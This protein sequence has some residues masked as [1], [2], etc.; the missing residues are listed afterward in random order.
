MF[1]QHIIFPMIYFL[2]KWKKVDGK[3]VVLADAHHDSCPP[4]ML[5]IRDKLIEENYK[6]REY[7]VDISKLSSL[8]GLISLAGFMRI[9]PSCGTVIICDNFLPVASCRKKKETKVIQLWHGCGAF[10]KFGYDATYDI[11]KGYKGNVYRNYDLVTVSGK[12][13]IPHF[14][15]AMNAYGKVLDTGVCHTDRLFDDKYIIGCK[16]RFAKYYPKAKGKKVLLWAPTFRGNAGMANL[17]GKA[18]IDKLGESDKLSD[19]YII[20]SIHPHLL[21]K[22]DSEAMNTDELMVC[23]DVL[24][25]DYS[26]VF[27][28]ALLLGIPVIFFA[29]DYDKYSMDRGFYL[30]YNSL[31]GYVVTSF[32]ELEKAVIKTISGEDEYKEIRDKFIGDYMLGCDGNATERV[33]SIISRRM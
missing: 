17:V 10:K 23:V 1:S 19:A 14:E 11:P 28:E 20:K 4:H 24:I 26:S 29:P 8:R 15:S 33:M 6:V 18:E 31:P 30:E 16:D 7:F 25:T 27:Y 22:K 2:N 13:C 12:K 5:E 9:Y 21:E 32:E 3:L